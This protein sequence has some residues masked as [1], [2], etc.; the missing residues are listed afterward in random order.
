[1]LYSTAC[2]NLWDQTYWSSASPGGRS[3]QIGGVP[4]K[5]AGTLTKHVKNLRSGTL[6][7]ELWHW[8]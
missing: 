2:S 5:P 8:K 7:Q 1:L 6:S 3:D 4:T